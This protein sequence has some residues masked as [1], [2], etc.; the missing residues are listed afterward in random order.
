[1]AP[2]LLF[3]LPLALAICATILVPV[4]AALHSGL[5]DQLLSSGPWL[6]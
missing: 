5:A 4:L 2:R 1:M 6:H 3:L